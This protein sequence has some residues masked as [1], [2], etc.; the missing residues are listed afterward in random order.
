MKILVVILI[1]KLIFVSTIQG[2]NK[3][4]IELL[5]KYRIENDLNIVENSKS[6]T[7]LAKKHATH[8]VETNTCINNES[9]NIIVFHSSHNKI[10]NINTKIVGNSVDFN[11]ELNDFVSWVNSNK[12]NEN[13]LNENIN[14]I[15]YYYN[16][17]PINFSNIT[18]FVTFS[19]LIME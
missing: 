17:T 18:V 1:F 10:E 13:M 8:L 3:T 7:E 2:Q 11:I 9:N 6:L 12:H 14:Y 5:N 16:T 15:G 4:F 19:V